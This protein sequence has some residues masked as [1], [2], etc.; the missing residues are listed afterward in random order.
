MNANVM[1]YIYGLGAVLLWSTVATAFKLSLQFYSPIQLL[2][3]AVITS[4][5]AL[6]TIIKWQNK[7]SLITRQLITRPLFYIQTALLN[8]F[9]Y[10]LMLFKAYDI[11][12]AQQALALNYTWAILLPILAVPLLHQKLK[13]TDIIATL[14]GYLGV[15][16]IATNGHIFNVE[17]ANISGVLFALAST[18]F[19]CLY[20]II[21]TKDKG[22]PIVSLCLSFIISLP[23]IFLALIMFDSLPSINIPS[24]AA[25]IYVGLFEMGLTFI[26]WLLALKSSKCTANISTMAFLTPLLSLIFISVIL[27]ESITQSTMIGMSF[28]IV[29]IAIQRLLP[30]YLSVKKIDV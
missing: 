24:L 4:I 5:I 6:L 27:N 10:Y 22:D 26:L 2:F 28:I 18:V 14:L 16:F 12:P 13:L 29:A 19:W 20:W 8:P 11:L 30:R 9:L 1:P 21:N 17:F 23:F 7:W 3:I 25:A 15:L